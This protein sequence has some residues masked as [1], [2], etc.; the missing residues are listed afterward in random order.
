MRRLF[1]F[2][3]LLCSVTATGETTGV[4]LA[5]ET[6]TISTEVNV[7]SVLATV[8]DRDG[9]VANELTKDDFV[10]LEDGV[11]QRIDY[12]SR[13]TDLPL[14]VGLLVDTSRS[15]K[16]VLEEERTASY[17]FLDQVLR[18]NDDR[19]FVV[20]FDT[21][22]QTLQGLTSSRPELESALAD[23]SIPP[24]VATL[25]FSAIHDSS[26]NL[27][28]KQTGRKAFILLTDGVAFR[29]PVSIG[30]AIEFAQRSDTIIFPIRFSD[31]IP[32]YRPMRAAV[33]GAAKE[34]GKEGLRRMA[35]ETGGVY[36]EVKGDRSLE[37]IYTEIAEIL[38]NQYSIGYTPP[39]ADRDGKFH[40]IKLTTK[41]RHLVVHARDGYYAE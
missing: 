2:I 11:P 22:V 1:V 13:E 7:V 28:H 4:L 24:E 26:E 20:S 5:Q 12:F 25:I 18:E 14:T 27:M 3:G 16:G 21:R 35:K 8:H 41:D 36:Y 31:A 6:P 30:S 32:A 15:Q 34:R 40:K 10:L 23:L 33:I 37:S 29:D 19:A 17:T 9:R 39:R 38:R